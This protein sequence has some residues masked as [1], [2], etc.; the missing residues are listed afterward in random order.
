MGW[1]TSHGTSFCHVWLGHGHTHSFCAL[2]KGC[3]VCEQVS[4]CVAAKTRTK[5]MWNDPGVY[6]HAHPAFAALPVCMNTY[7]LWFSLNTEGT[8]ILYPKTLAH[9]LKDW[10]MG[11]DQD[12]ALIPGSTPG[13]QC[14]LSVWATPLLQGHAAQVC[15][16][17]P[18]PA[19][20]HFLTI[21]F[22]RF[23]Y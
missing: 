10:A 5:F 22:I 8:A 21:H 14:S 20:T 6:E 9:I 18:I 23:S 4:G 15:H 12:A 3:A 1:Q 16:V 2:C 7:Y 19:D 17:A 13:F 11:W